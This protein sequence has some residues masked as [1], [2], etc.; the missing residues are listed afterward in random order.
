MN[1]LPTFTLQLTNINV[2]KDKTI[3]NLN[4]IRF[5]FLYK[6]GFMNILRIFFKSFE[7]LLF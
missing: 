2:S 1:T 5:L 4:K 7:F 3:L 6:D